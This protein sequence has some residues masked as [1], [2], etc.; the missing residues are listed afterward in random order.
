[1]EEIK[2]AFKKFQK[3]CQKETGF[4]LTGC[5]YMTKRQMQNN[6]ATIIICNSISY[7][8]L[9]QYYANSISKAMDWDDTKERKASIVE[10]NLK[11]LSRLSADFSQYG[12][13]ENYFQKMC[14]K[15][16]NSKAWETFSTQYNVTMCREED[17][18][19]MRIRLFY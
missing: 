7:E 1:M 14:E 8:T 2:K 12:T 5:C 15:I 19:V 9:I 18:S 13:K 11:Y 6:T 17:D 4:D 3:D 16:L 10:S